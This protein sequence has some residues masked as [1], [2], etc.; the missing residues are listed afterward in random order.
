MSAASPT[1]FMSTVLPPALGPLTIKTRA[2]EPP[3]AMSLATTAP[4]AP[5]S[6]WASASR[7]WRASFKSTIGS[8]TIEIAVPP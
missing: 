1:V 4:F 6:A 3:S 5:D 2:A 7:G 8:S